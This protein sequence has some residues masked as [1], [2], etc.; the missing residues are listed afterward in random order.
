MIRYSLK[1][2][3]GHPF[4]SWFKS[5]DAFADLSARGLVECPDC[6]SRSVEKTL[7]APAVSKDKPL[8]SPRDSREADLAKL[9]EAVEKNSEYVGLKF[10][11]EA[12]A[13]HLGDKPSRAI[14]GEAK[15]EEAKALIEDGIPVAPLP[16]K[17]SK[18]AH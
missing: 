6:G 10:A 15:V 5:A 12:R 18:Q 3:D 9:R 8:R 2:T 13:M 4:E 16:F 7:M 14:Y 1:C 11:D 17:P